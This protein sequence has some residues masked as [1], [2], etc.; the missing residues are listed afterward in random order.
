MK[1]VPVM[2]A[3]TM[4]TMVIAMVSMFMLRFVFDALMFD[5]KD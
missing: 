5:V 2:R 4:K 1:F 3:R